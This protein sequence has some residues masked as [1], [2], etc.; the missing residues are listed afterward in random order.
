MEELAK[1][2]ADALKQVMR[3]HNATWGEDYAIVIS[4]DAV[5]YGDEGWGSGNF[6]FFGVGDEAYQK[7]VSFE[8]QLTQECLIGEITPEKIQRFIDHTVDR[9]DPRA[10]KWTWCGRFSVPFGVLTAYYLQKFLQE[11]T[12]KS[13]ELRG[14][15][16]GYAT[17][18]DHT[19]LKVDDIGLGVTA[20]AHQRHWVG[21]PAIAYE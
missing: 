21:Y 15:L 19:P 18:I 9:E 1:I 20:P 2:L 11:L 12:G 17:S 5:H 3:K 6:A 4:A 14:K 16:V 8:H 10:Y 7:A 13:D